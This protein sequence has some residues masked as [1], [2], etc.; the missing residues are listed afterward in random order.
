MGDR[1]LLWLSAVYTVEASVII[2]ISLILIAAGILLAFEVFREDMEVIRTIS[3]Q[4]VHRS[5]SEAADRFRLAE[6]A[7][8]VI[9]R[10][11]GK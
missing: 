5:S 10:I 7:T 3:R 11:R 8:E 1:N 6:T 9:E 4:I 2:S